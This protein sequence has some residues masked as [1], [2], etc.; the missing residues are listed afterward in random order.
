MK[1]L[2]R[3]S[4]ILPVLVPLLLSHRCHQQSTDWWLFCLKCWHCLLDLLMRLSWSFPKSSSENK[5]P[6]WAPTVAPNQSLLML[7]LKSTTVVALSL[8]CLITRIRLALMLKFL[9][10]AHKAASQTLSKAFLKSMQAWW[11]PCWCWRYVSQMILS[12][13]ICSVVLLTPL[14]LLV[15]QWWCSQFVASICSGWPSAWRLRLAHAA[16]R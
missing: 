16:D 6:W 5:H 7:P 13:K 3:C 12:L 4:T 10:V 11:R 2:S 14:S 15:L 8:R 9:K 1:V